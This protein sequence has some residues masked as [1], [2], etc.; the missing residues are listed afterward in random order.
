MPV[1]LTYTDS[2]FNSIIIYTSLYNNFSA[3]SLWIC[4][5][6]D[7]SQKQQYNTEPFKV[8]VKNTSIQVVSLDTPSSMSVVGQRNC[9]KI[10]FLKL[11]NDQ[12]LGNTPLGY[13]T[14]LTLTFLNVQ[15]P[16]F[17]LGVKIIQLPV[18]KY[19]LFNFKVSLGIFH[20]RTEITFSLTT[21]LPKWE[22]NLIVLIL[23]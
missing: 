7:R 4:Y 1:S 13:I 23:T 15:I 3:G 14:T 18:S 2:I 20:F 8:L 6:S 19:P 17:L 11:E 9:I 10:F 16:F 5:C 12:D 21:E 22:K